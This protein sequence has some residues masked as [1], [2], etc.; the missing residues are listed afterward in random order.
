MKMSV[1]VVAFLLVVQTASAAVEYDFRQSMH[2]DVESVPSAD[3]AGHAVIDGDRTRVDFLSGTAFPPGTYVI[4]T[5]GS[6]SQTWVD[7]SKKS[8]VEINT[9]SVAS[10]IGASHITI[11]NKKINVEQL[12]DHMTIAGLPTDHYRLTISYDITLQFGQIPLRQAVSTVIDKWTTNA[13]AGVVESFLASGS[14][15]T[16]NADVDELIDAEN[17]KIKGFALK[18]TVNVT[19]INTTPQMPGSQLKLKQTRTQTRDLTITAIQAKADVS[20]AL[21]SV[22]A[23]FRKADPLRDDSQK[24]PL[25]VLNM[26]PAAQ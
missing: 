15:R 17:S 16:G 4:C 24:A 3:F 19:T 6:R 21:F 18:E 22:P 20:N 23:G 12:P 8:Y 10:A 9:G 26:E 2:S 11:A 1:V 7:P 25:H 14:I 13:Y 5:N